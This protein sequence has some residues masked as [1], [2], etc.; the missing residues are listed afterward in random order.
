MGIPVAG[1]VAGHCFHRGFAAQGGDHINMVEYFRIDGLVCTVLMS[2]PNSA[3]DS[4][5][6]ALMEDPGLLFTR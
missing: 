2:V 5:D 4:T 3:K 1:L 6:C